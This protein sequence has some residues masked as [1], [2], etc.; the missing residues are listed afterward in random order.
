MNIINKSNVKRL[1]LEVS[2]Q[3]RNGKFKR[4]GKDFLDRIEAATK[5][6][7]VSEVKHH[8]SIGITLK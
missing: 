1:A 7:I 8:P 2:E 6:Y 3:D 4:V 5:Q